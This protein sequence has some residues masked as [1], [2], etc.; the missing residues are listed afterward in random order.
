MREVMEIHREKP[1]CAACHARMDPIGLGLE[2]FNA[3]GMWRDRENGKPIDTAGQ[4]ITGEKFKNVDEL[5]RILTSSRR[6]DFYRCLA[7]KLLT[8]A[9]G[10][11]PEYFDSPTIDRLAQD[12][13]RDGGRLQT[14]LYG[15][16]E[17]TPFQK[18]RGDGEKSP[19]TARR[20]T[21]NQTE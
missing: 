16:T 13:D 17:S 3:L 14:L 15:I 2:N 10:R 5:S 12:L 19:T 18:R 6:M 20:A 11:G 21:A 4:L 1:L 7:E 9:I 8:Y